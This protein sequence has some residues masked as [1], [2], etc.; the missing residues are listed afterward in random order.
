MI[1]FALSFYTVSLKLYSLN[2]PG[3][4]LPKTLQSKIFPYSHII[5][6]IVEEN[7]LENTFTTVIF[8][9]IFPKILKSYSIIH[10]VGIKDFLKT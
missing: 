6:I 2:S 5:A 3:E 4:F 7:Y 8:R 9:E 10:I 1:L